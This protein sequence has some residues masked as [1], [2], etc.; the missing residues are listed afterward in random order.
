ML[1]NF[2]QNELDRRSLFSLI[3]FYEFL[4]RYSV[5]EKFYESKKQ[6]L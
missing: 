2:Y 6:F 4:E 5:N 3:V 1:Q